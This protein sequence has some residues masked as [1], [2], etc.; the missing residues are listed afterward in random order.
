VNEQGK[1]LY[2]RV[3]EGHPLLWAAARKAACETQFNLYQGEHKR[4]G[5]MHF[6]SDDSGF[7]GIPFTANQVP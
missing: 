6:Y 7:I 5:V 1:T 2:A 4:Q 3:L